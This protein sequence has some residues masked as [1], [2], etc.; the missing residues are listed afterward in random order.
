[1]T[2]KNSLG[3]AVV[4]RFW[5]GRPG[6]TVKPLFDLLGE[7]D[8]DFGSVIYKR[9]KLTNNFLKAI[10]G[11]ASDGDV[12]RLHIAAHGRRGPRR[13]HGRI[14]GVSHN[15]TVAAIKPGRGR[16]EGVFLAAC[17]VGR[18]L[19]SRILREADVEWVAYYN[20]P[21]PWI[22]SAFFEA[23]FWY[24]FHHMKSIDRVARKINQRY[25]A[26]SDLLGFRILA[27]RDDDLIPLVEVKR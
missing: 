13:G 3:L 7:D 15:A 12:L 23:E 20:S 17:N 21:A 14:S 18:T 16:I 4:E 10:K 5:N 27:R 22:P 25:H 11:F 8:R 6:Y 2:K 19:P 24:H 9:T 26:L 1:M